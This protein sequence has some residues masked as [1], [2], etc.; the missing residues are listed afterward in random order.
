[1]GK[2]LCEVSLRDVLHLIHYT[3]IPE[4][5]TD[6]IMKRMSVLSIK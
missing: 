4:H 5:S 2:G 1:M 6:G 3:Y